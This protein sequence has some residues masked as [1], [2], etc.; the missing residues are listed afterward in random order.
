MRLDS[1]ID[2]SKNFLPISVFS[3]NRILIM[4]FFAT[5][6][7]FLLTLLSCVTIHENEYALRQQCWREFQ[8]VWRRIEWQR[9]RKQKRRGKFLAKSERNSRGCSDA[10]PK[11]FRG[12]SLTHQHRRQSPVASAEPMNKRQ[13]CHSEWSSASCLPDGMRIN[14]DVTPAKAGVHCWS[15]AQWLPA[16]AGMT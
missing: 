15:G 12:L 3:E 13:R 8:K 10:S 2:R 4:H 9:K 14:C 11:F 16:F 6:F 7:T 1:G 5:N